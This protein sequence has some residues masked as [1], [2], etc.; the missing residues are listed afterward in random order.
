MRRHSRAGGKSPNAQVPKPARK[1]HI[2]LKG[3]A[4]SKLS[5]AIEET[6][7]ARLTRE[8]SEERKQRTATAPAKNPGSERA[9]MI[10]T[11]WTTLDDP[12]RFQKCPSPLDLDHAMAECSEFNCLRN[13]PNHSSGPISASERAAC[14]C[15][16]VPWLVLRD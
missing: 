15:A 10:W 6:E 13:Y 2:A 8:L 12:S 7:V 3:R 4:R 9:K 16:P 14:M 1:S 11:T 5:H